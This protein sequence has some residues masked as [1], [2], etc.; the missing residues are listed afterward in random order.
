M[1]TVT[2]EPKTKT[3]RRKA[4]AKAKATTSK[5]RKPKAKE[6]PQQP[7][8]S[9]ESRIEQ[10]HKLNDLIEQH[11]PISIDALVERTGYTKSRVVGHVARNEQ[12]SRSRVQVAASDGATPTT[13]HR[14]SAAICQRRGTSERPQNNATAKPA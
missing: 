2:A 3:R 9:G 5:A 12:S 7:E 6:A 13:I 14:P 10:G 4:S 8:Q 11:S 1:S